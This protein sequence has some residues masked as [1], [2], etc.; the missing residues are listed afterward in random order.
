MVEN[1]YSPS[2]NLVI[3]IPT[4]NEADNIQHTIEEVFFEL[5]KLSNYN[6]Y[7]LI[8]DSA[9]DDGTQE[10]VAHL[11]AQYSNL[12]LK[13]E[14]VKSGLGS[15]YYQAINYVTSQLPIDIIFEF[16]ADLSHQPK[17]I[18]DMV[19]LLE[20]Y[21]CVVGSRY[22]KGGSIPKNW[23]TYRKILSKL[24]NQIARILL[25]RKYRDLTS[26]FRGTRTRILRQVITDEFISKDY[27]YKLELFWRLH[28][29]KA[30]IVEFPIDFE[31]RT[32]GHSKLPPNSV[33][34]SL[35]VLTTLRAR[36]LLGYFKMCLIGSTGAIIQLIVYNILR[37]YFSPLFSS[38]LAVIAAL[39]NNYLLNSK[40][41]FGRNHLQKGMEYK[42]FILFFLYSLG[43]IFFQSTL[44]Q[45]S[46]SYFGGGFI[47]E[48]LILVSVI[49][50]CSIANYF[51][52]S[53]NI[54]PRDKP[55]LGERK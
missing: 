52:Y 55:T 46:V 21:D 5:D 18:P 16:D 2:T 40:Y 9:S 38:Q 47:K 44:I 8:F 34:D 45:A 37:L 11:Q 12:I 32:L 6:S 3:I 54:W 42:R 23:G 43:I 1:L 53:R 49:F 19:K 24:G 14:P 35:K 30:Q 27:A 48:N 36:E 7:I 41:N 31:D 51:I 10:I 50:I 13:S 28:K 4:Y 17:Y 15:A 29:Y 22:V 20:K 25:T 33:Q 26:G 39:I